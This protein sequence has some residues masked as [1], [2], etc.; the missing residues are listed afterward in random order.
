MVGVLAV[1]FCDRRAGQGGV[2]LDLWSYPDGTFNLVIENYGGE[3]G[4]ELAF[5]C[6]LHQLAG[7]LLNKPFMSENDEGVLQIERCG[8][9]VCAEFV[10]SH[11]RKGFRYCI[12]L[13]EYQQA[14]EA[15][16]SWEVGYL[17]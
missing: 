7:P 5:P 14:I 17:A 13:D 2:C 12:G 15:L 16:E 8:N 9:Q 11:S 1:S 10:P 4:K 6:A 3:K